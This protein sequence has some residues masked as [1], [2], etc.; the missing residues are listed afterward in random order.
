[1]SQR[2]MSQRTVPQL[3]H[4]R[5][6]PM[7]R[8][9]S[10]N[11]A[12]MATDLAIPLLA[13]HGWAGLTVAAIAA[14]GNM[15]RQS[16]AQWFG[17]VEAMREQ[18]A[19][20]YARRWLLLLSDQLTVLYGADSP[21]AGKVAQLLLPKDDDGIV[22]AR[23]WLSVGEAGRSD[24][25]IGAA[26]TFAEAEQHAM[27]ERWLPRAEQRELHA[28]T[29]LVTGLRAHLCSTDPISLAAAQASVDS[30]RR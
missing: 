4:S 29:A 13:E 3:S 1:M 16:V 26:T 9:R 5:V 23:I 20:R 10:L 30:L 28:V 6:E 7:F 8:D 27:V 15:R 11:R 19:W 14:R 2:I 21:D 22:F 25:S 18:I 24:T 17:N 12:E